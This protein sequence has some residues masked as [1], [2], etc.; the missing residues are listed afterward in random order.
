MSRRRSSR[1]ADSTPIQAGPSI[2]SGVAVGD[3]VAEAASNAVALA[4]GMAVDS[5]I[6]T[7]LDP[8]TVTGTPAERLAKVEAALR[9]ADEHAARSVRAAKI[10]WTIESGAALKI[11]VDDDLYTAR[12]YT[13]LDAYA[14]EVLHISRTNVYKTIE[15]GAALRTVLSARRVSKIFD[16][17]PNA[18]QARAL[19]PVL[20]LTDG[21]GKAVN[22]ITD[23]KASGKKLTA[24]AITAAAK[25]LGCTGPVIPSPAPSTDAVDAERRAEAGRRLAAAADAAE[26]VLAL[27]EEVLVADIAPADADRAA[28]DLTRLAKAGR[29]LAKQTRIPGT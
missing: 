6:P 22:V 27:Y 19:V 11:L 25:R 7:P 14:D 9:A 8:E 12:G 23:V 21:E 2:T 26:R 3:Q 10:R 4:G 24:A 20:G 28:A 29:V 17:P 15:A 5:F 16:T 13:S 1:T 18:S